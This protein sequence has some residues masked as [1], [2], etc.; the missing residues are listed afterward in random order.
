MSAERARLRV[1]DPL[2]GD[3]PN[4]RCRLHPE[5]M[6]RLDLDPGDA[7]EITSERGTAAAFAYP[8]DWGSWGVEDAD[9]DAIHVAL[10][11][12]LGGDRD[13]VRG[14]RVGVRA[15][16][17]APARRVVHEA[18]PPGTSSILL[19]ALAPET[20]AGTLAVA[21]SRLVTHAA[22]GHRQGTALLRVYDT[23]PSGVVVVTEATELSARHTSLADRPAQTTLADFFDGFEPGPDGNSGSDISARGEKT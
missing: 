21:G 19:G 1:A 13:D 6:A 15:V 17:P 20:L 10:S 5:V 11:A 9:P 3:L 2:F 22:R 12:L 16:S 18:Y 7:V 14:E 23:E 8:T 4:N